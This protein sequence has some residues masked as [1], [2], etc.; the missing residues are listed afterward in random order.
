M[1]YEIIVTASALDPG[2]SGNRFELERDEPL[3]QGQ[4][5][6]QGD[7]SYRVLRVLPENDEY[8]GVIEVEHVGGPTEVGRG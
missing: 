6:L 2:V 8:D 7:M 3:E 1:V 5:F 4:R